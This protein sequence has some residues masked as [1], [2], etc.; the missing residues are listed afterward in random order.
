MRR[1]EVLEFEDD[2]LEGRFWHS[3]LPFGYDVAI[4]D[5]RFVKAKEL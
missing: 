4:R 5:L 2:F 3:I 1:P